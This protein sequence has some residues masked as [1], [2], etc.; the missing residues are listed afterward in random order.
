M[1][2]QSIALG[3]ALVAA[4]A[5]QSSEPAKGSAQQAP[6]ATAKD[7][8]AAKQLLAAGAVVVDVRT[9]EEFA[10]GHVT[11]AVNLPVQSFAPADVDKL[12]GGDKSKPVVVYC[13]AG[14]RAAKA[15]ASLEA[16]GYTNVVNG[17]GYD[18][19]VP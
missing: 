3:L 14:K 15:K 8:A 13:A 19:L 5:C 17:G 10:D 4:G 7:P 1:T 11:N 6:A 18:D 12:T 9:P 16:A 2:L